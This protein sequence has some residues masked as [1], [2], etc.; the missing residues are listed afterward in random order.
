MSFKALTENFLKFRQ[1]S[2]MKKEIYNV[3]DVGVLVSGE[4]NA[5][6]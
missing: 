3:C 1:R 4:R 5:I 2:M 6:P